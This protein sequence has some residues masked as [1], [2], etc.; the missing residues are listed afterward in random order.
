MA[1]K[2]GYSARKD[3][4]LGMRNGREKKMKQP[5]KDRRAES[6]G[7]EGSMGV[8]GHEKEPR[9]IDAYA[10][11]TRDMGRMDYKKSIDRGYPD[12]AMD[13]QY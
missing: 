1:H 3:E 10:A 2:Q 5:Y 8:M 13:Y 12:K 9:K 4:S 11:Q 7:M 6:Y